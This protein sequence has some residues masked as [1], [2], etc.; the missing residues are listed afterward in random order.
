MTLTLFFNVMT[1]TRFM[2]LR[3]TFSCCDL[4]NKDIYVL[5]PSEKEKSGIC[6]V[7]GQEALQHESA[8]ER[9]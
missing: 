6:L 1:F 2:K 3:T 5:V 4:V 9:Q 8:P 7:A